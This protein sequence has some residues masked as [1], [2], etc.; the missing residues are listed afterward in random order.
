MRTQKPVYQ[1]TCISDKQSLSNEDNKV[2]EKKK[3]LEIKIPN[4]KRASL[5]ARQNLS[6]G[7]PVIKKLHQKQI[8]ISVLLCIQKV[9]T[10]QS[11]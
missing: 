5:K 7:Q 8:K 3:H 10:V 9:D 2:L 1:T 11:M 6:L 4:H